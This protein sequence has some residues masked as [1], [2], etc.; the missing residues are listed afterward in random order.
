MSMAGKEGYFNTHNAVRDI[1]K[2]ANFQQTF[3]DHPPVSFLALNQQHLSKK[4]EG[5]PVVNTLLR[6]LSGD[7]AHTLSTHEPY[8]G[9]YTIDPSKPAEEMQQ[10]ISE[11]LA[12]VG[13]EVNGIIDA[14]SSSGNGMFAKT[15]EVVR[16]QLMGVAGIFRGVPER[17]IAAH[18]KSFVPTITGEGPSYYQKL[19]DVYNDKIKLVDPSKPTLS[20]AGLV[21]MADNSL[22]LLANP[23]SNDFAYF[24]A[25]SLIFHMGGSDRYTLTKKTPGSFSVNDTQESKRAIEGIRDAYPNQQSDIITGCPAIELFPLMIRR[26]NAN[27]RANFAA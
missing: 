25:W 4:G 10:F 22:R 11:Q 3:G 5:K 16:P 7:V 26:V 19:I 12:M 9:L 23:A 21:D 8:H 18:L 13:V 15:L 27:I 2:G 20:L 14:V 17:T 6:A 24:S 1:M